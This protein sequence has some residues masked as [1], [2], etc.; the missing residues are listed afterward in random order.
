[1]YLGGRFLE[2]GAPGVPLRAR[3]AAARPVAPPRR[4]GR[5]HVPVTDEQPPEASRGRRGSRRSGNSD[6]AARPA[7]REERDPAVRARDI[8]LR[9]LTMGPRTAAQL[10]A[11]MVKREIDEDTIRE[12]LARFTEVGLI[13]DAA[14]AAAWVESRHAGRG[15]ARRALAQELRHRGVAAEQVA[16]AV[17]E[18]EPEREVATARA[19]AER[20][21]ASNRGQDPTVRFRRTAALLARKGYSSALSYRVIREALEAEGADSGALPDEATF[22]L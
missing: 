21:L 9:Q 14:F 11:A 18:L 19:L 13:D 5:R 8:C 20:R 3:R 1:C 12:V 22:T 7:A 2:R 10:A 17:A 4:G 15:L 6:E 16:V